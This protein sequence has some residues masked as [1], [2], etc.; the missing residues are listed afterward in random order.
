MATTNSWTV[1]SE[2]SSPYWLP[3]FAPG[4]IAGQPMKGFAVPTPSGQMWSATPSSQKSG[5]EGYIN[6]WA[7]SVA[8]MVASY[9][10]MVDRIFRMLPK[11]SPYSAAR[12]GTARQW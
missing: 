12:W 8:G 2:A 10:D 7:G 9:Q 5:M 11:R 1:P 6:R 3:K 4:E